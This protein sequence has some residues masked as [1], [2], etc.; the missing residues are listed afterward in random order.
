MGE[1][2]L[3]DVDGDEFDGFIDRVSLDCHHLA[4]QI[5]IEEITTNT[6]LA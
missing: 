1:G 4:K 6:H 2:A 3:I 5:V